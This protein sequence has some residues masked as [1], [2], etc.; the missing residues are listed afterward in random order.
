M[1]SNETLDL[2]LTKL[3]TVDRIL[4]LVGTNSE[5]VKSTKTVTGSKKILDITARK[6]PGQL[7]TKET[8][9]KIGTK[10]LVKANNNKAIYQQQ[11]RNGLSLSATEQGRGLFLVTR[12]A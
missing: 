10:M 8:F 3:E 5:S 1:K 12:T 7:L 11:N 4:E 6:A 2:L 9:K